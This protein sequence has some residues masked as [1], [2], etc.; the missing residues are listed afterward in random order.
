M[1]FSGH[2]DEVNCLLIVENQFLLSSS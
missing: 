1:T 2:E